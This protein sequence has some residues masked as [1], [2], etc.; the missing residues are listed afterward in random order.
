M[1]WYRLAADK[2]YA[3][4]QFFLGIMYDDGYGVPE[5]DTE[6]VKWWRLAAD[7]GVAVAQ[8]NLGAMYANGNGVPEDYIEGYARFNVAVALG[9]EVAKD[10]KETLTAKMSKEDISAAQKRSKEIWE[11]L[12]ARKAD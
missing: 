9:D 5:D 12:E 3:T 10:L 4:A 1:K 6:A 11:A 7:Q 8:S 2:G